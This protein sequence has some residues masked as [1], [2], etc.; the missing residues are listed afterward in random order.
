MTNDLSNLNVSM[1]QARRPS[2]FVVRHCFVIVA[3]LAGAGLPGCYERKETAVLNPDGSGKMYVE[4]VM[5]IPSQGLPGKEK[6]TALSF[7]RQV[8]AELINSTRGVDAWADLAITEVDGGKAKVAVTAYFNDLNALKFDQ[9]LVFVWK[10]DAQGATLSL[11]RARSGVQSYSD[12]SDADLKTLIAQAQSDYKEQR[13]ALQTQLNAYKLDMSLQLPGEITDSQ[14]FQREGNTVSL[15]IDG[16]KA[17]QALDKFMADENALRATFKAGQ[18][19]PAN[20]DLMLNS[21]YGRKGPLRVVLKIAPDAK[22]LFDYRTEVR[23]AQIFQSQMIKDAGVELI[24]KFIVTPST[25]T[26]PA[27]RPVTRPATRGN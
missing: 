5:A 16:K 26:R 27:T 14:I 24:P 2:S 21:I 8:A 22:P 17:I 7:G 10:R 12:I 9:T 25:Q 11:E 13:L 23:A 19:L 3:I 18:D 6:P 20:D 15:T 1:R 4:T